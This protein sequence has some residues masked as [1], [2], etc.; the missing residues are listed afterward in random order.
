MGLEFFEFSEQIFALI[1]LEVFLISFVEFQ[2]RLGENFLL[3]FPVPKIHNSDILAKEEQS[4]VDAHHENAFSV[5]EVL[6]F[7]EE[8][9][10]ER[11]EN[12][13]ED[14][15]EEQQL[16]GVSVFVAEFLGVGENGNEPESVGQD[17]ASDSREVEVNVPIVGGG[18]ARKSVDVG[19]KEEGEDEETGNDVLGHVSEGNESLD[20][21]VDVVQNE[22]L[23]DV[24]DDWDGQ[25]E[26]NE[27]DVVLV[28]GLVVFENQVEE[29]ELIATQGEDGDS[30]LIPRG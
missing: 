2:R 5:Q 4:H 20:E 17:V 3:V 6:G 30:F 12:E 22:H 9:E 15:A 29:L 25:E 8:D 19:N 18:L 24:K 23:E 7:R 13:S 28:E 26:E 11:E 14:N 10:V 16:K 21:G 1:S 27:E